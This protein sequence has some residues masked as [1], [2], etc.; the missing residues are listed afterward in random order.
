[1]QKIAFLSLMLSFLCSTV[2]SIVPTTHDEFIF[3]IHQTFIQTIKIYPTHYSYDKNKNLQTFVF[4]GTAENSQ[5]H[6]LLKRFSIIIKLIIRSEKTAFIRAYLQADGYVFPSMNSHEPIN[7]KVPLEYT[8]SG[9]Y[10][11]EIENELLDD[12]IL[13]L[14]DSALFF[15]RSSITCNQCKQQLW[16][17]SPNSDEYYQ[18]NK[19]YITTQGAIYCPKCINAWNIRTSGRSF[20]KIDGLIIPVVSFKEI[21]NRLDRAQQYGGVW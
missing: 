21:T 1:M 6:P 5:E 15:E 7:I 3:T 17:I 8:W 14:L 9:K 20:K 19:H 4:S 10:K 12:C 16:H 13:Q 18:L 11:C 2:Q